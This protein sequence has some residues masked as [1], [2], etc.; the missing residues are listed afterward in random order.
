[1]TKA[2]EILNELNTHDVEDLH[3]NTGEIKSR[4]DYD[5]I[6][7][8]YYK[9]LEILRKSA[10]NLTEPMADLVVKDANGELFCVDDIMYNNYIINDM[11]G[12][13][14]MLDNSNIVDIVEEYDGKDLREIKIHELRKGEVI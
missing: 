3:K 12:I 13:L 2:I 9:L 5:I 7:N 1:M 8:K 6:S 14:S 11:Y 4:N 10:L